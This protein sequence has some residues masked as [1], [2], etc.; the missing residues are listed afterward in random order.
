[1]LK[2]STVRGSA[3][4][5]RP[6]VPHDGSIAREIRAYLHGACHIRFLRVLANCHASAKS[7]VHARLKFAAPLIGCSAYHAFRL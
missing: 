7:S 1:M 4:S 2:D 5:L 3:T 6:V